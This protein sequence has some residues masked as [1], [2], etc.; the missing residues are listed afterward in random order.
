M[1][2][3]LLLPE[4]GRNIVINTRLLAKM[5]QFQSEQTSDKMI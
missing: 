5:D 3:I 1:N 2:R 4:D